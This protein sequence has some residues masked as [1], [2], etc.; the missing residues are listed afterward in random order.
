MLG[1]IDAGGEQLAGLFAFIPRFGEANVRVNAQ[2]DPLLLAV[3]PVLETP[4][5]PAVLRDFEVH[6]ATIGKSHIF[7]LPFRLIDQ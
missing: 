4:P 7:G 3:N 6:A 1:R 2:G 5:F